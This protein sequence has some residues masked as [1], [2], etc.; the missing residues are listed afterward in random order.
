MISRARGERGLPGASANKQYDY[1]HRN[2][3]ALYLNED[4]VK[5]RLRAMQVKYDEYKE[6][7]DGYAGPAVVETFGEVPFEPVNKKKQ[8]LHLN[9]RQQK[10]PCRF[11]Q[12][13]GG[14][15]CKPLYQG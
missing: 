6:L 1:D 12:N 10:A 8:A 9:E 3:E 15:D 5:R 4:L 7:A 11:S 14:P 2:D 13:G